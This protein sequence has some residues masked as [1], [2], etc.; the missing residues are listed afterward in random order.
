LDDKGF[1][2]SQNLAGER[3]F[4]SQSLFI[5]KKNI[6]AYFLP[7]NISLLIFSMENTLDLCSL[8]LGYQGPVIEAD[9]K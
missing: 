3:K 7:S 2:F 4:W 5:Q 8:E 1:N 9:I 6:L